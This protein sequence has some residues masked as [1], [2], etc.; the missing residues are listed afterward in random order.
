MNAIAPNDKHSVVHSTFRIERTYAASPA[1]VFAAFAET[2]KKRRWFVEGDGWEIYQ[3]EADFNV[4]GAETSRFSFKGSPEVRN[5]TV[6][7]DIVPDQRIVFTYRMA[8]GPKPL[9]ASLTTIE[10]TPAGAG[11][12]LVY[13]E[14][15]AFF[16]GA[17][18]AQGREEGCRG[19]LEKLA[20]EV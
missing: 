18:S 2:E 13:T 7:Q 19:L 11:T 4:G 20:A 14:Q 15:G 16:D 10:L 8:I 5:D 3:Y 9:S 1:R 6:Y 17:D 12:L